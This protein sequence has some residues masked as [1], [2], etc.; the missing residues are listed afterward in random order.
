M[1]RKLSKQF[2]DV[3]KRYEDGL[4]THMELRNE[5]GELHY[6]WYFKKNTH[7][8]R[9]LREKATNVYRSRSR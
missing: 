3:I 9:S 2:D 6:D 4:I 8:K 5:L 1:N 7:R